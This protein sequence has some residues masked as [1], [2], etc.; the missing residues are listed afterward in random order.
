MANAMLQVFCCQCGR[1]FDAN[2]STITI[3]DIEVDVMATPCH[4]CGHALAHDINHDS[5]F[6]YRVAS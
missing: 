2:V 6:E 1:G 3:N 4:Y 5:Y